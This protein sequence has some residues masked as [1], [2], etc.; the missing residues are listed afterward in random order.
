MFLNTLLR[1]FGPVSLVSANPESP[2]FLGSRFR[3]GALDDPN[4]LKWTHM[5]VK[6]IN[7]NSYKSTPNGAAR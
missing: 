7:L 2:P 5:H 3:I 4:G 6:A 1:V